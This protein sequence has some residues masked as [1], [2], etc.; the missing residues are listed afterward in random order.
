MSGRRRVEVLNTDGGSRRLILCDAL[1]YAQKFR[2]RKSS[3][4]RRRSTGACVIALV[5]ARLRTSVSKDDELADQLLAAGN[6]SLD[7]AVAPA[8]LWDDYQLP[9]S[10]R[11]SPHVAN[12]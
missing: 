9:D 6:A 3:S 8:G 4:T 1:T 10:N 2:H 7:R 5:Q 12:P 11:V